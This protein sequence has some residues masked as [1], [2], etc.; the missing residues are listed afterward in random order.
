MQR[1][2]RYWIVGIVVTALVGGEIALTACSNYAEGERCQIG[3]GNDDCDDGLTCTPSSQLVGSNSDRCCPAD[4]STATQPICSIPTS[5]IGTDAAPPLETGPAN[6]AGT[7]A[8]RSE[9]GTEASTDAAE[10]G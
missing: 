5:G 1:A 2:R 9:T 4:R 7:D 3:N 6:E 10:G 8:N